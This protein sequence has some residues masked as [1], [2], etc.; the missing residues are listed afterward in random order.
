VP[1]IV[2]SSATQGPAATTV[3]VNLPTTGIDVAVG[4]RV[5]I[6]LGNDTGT[7]TITGPAGWSDISTQAAS[8]AVRG[9]VF[10]RTWDGTEGATATFTGTNAVWH[11]YVYVVKGRTSESCTRGDWNNVQSYQFPAATAS[12]NNALTLYFAVSDGTGYFTVPTEQMTVYGRAGPVE[13]SGLVTMTG[14]RNVPTAGAVPRP[15]MDHNLANEGGN[16]FVVVIEDDGT[17]EMGPCLS[18]V[19]PFCKTLATF[20]STAAYTW[21]DASSYITTLNGIPVVA[22]TQTVGTGSSTTDDWGRPCGLTAVN[23][24]GGFAG[25]SIALPGGPF[26]VIDCILALSYFTSGSSTS[27]SMGNDGMVIVMHDAAN[28][29]LAFQMSNKANV[30]ANVQKDF[31]CAPGYSTPYATDGTI[32]LSDF[33]RVSFLMHRGGTL[34]FSFLFKML[35]AYPRTAA[36]CGGTADFPLTPATFARQLALPGTSLRAK[37]STSLVEMKTSYQFGD[38]TTKTYSNLATAVETPLP[39]SVAARRIEWNV[40]AN[41]VAV[42]FVAS[43]ADTIVLNST[44][45]AG[46]VAMDWQHT[47]SASATVSA[48]GNVIKGCAVTLLNGETYAGQSYSGC[49]IAVGTATLSG[50]AVSGGSGTQ[51]ATVASGAAITGGSFTRGTETYAI[52]A[53]EA[54]T[55]NLS[56]QTFTGYTNVLNVTATTG[57]LTVTLA[58]GQTPPTYVTAGAAV[59]WDQASADT[60]WTNANLANGT[61]VLV[62]NID[63]GTTIDF[64]V[65][66]GGTGYAITMVPGVD[67]T[68]G[69][70]IEIRQSRKS[71]TTYYIER[72]SVINT[73]GGGGSILEVDPLAVC[74]I[75][76]DLDIDGEDFVSVFD[77]DSADDELDLITAGTWQTG[78]LM[79]WWKYEM[80]LQAPME[81]FWGAWSV[82]SDGSFRN[83]VDTLPSL[84]DT[85]ETGDSIESTGRRIHRSDGARPIR[86]PTTGG[87]SIDLSWRDPVTVVATGSGVLPAD[88]TAIGAE[89]WAN[90]PGVQVKAKTD[91]L[92]FTVAGQLDANIQYVNDVQV[93][94]V[95][96]DANPWNPA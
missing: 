38:G 74:P 18:T 54:G 52:T 26:D 23:V 27:A 59:E 37:Y 92:T 25:T 2:S 83:D 41:R 21:E 10:A 19:T 71:G 68:V 46:N 31:F 14:A 44:T 81:E 70:T 66:S 43:A 1:I 60:T 30:V 69:D 55:L 77:L 22:L 86:S 47:G 62:R 64:A 3:A 61:A 15:V 75:C 76:T 12:G 87:G 33:R 6:F 88:I 11:A 42:R 82:Q 49:S 72:T 13:M 89:V 20:F 16:V 29:K 57:T 95:G 45:Q 35:Q 17:A 67:Y 85:T 58:L 56:S 65:T 48:P 96:T 53:T 94:G 91:A 32:D 34:S 7:T 51:A 5:I 78:Q 39:Y 79:A 93:K 9:A 8:G 40:P 50:A 90:T 73:T 36:M 63:T 28:N 80:T 84:I 24:N 4:Q